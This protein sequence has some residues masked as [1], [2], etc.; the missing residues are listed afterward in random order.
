MMVEKDKEK[1]HG[2]DKGGMGERGKNEDGEG[3]K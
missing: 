1:R 3:N 2:G